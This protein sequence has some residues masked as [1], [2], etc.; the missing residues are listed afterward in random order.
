ML[1]LA[2][3]QTSDQE[4]RADI[5]IKAQQDL[6]FAGLH[7]TV[8]N[9]IANFTGNCPSEKAFK[10]IQQTIKNIHVLKAVNYNVN[11][12]PVK[13]DTLTPIKLQVD[14]LLAQYPQ[15]IAKVDTASIT[16]KGTITALNKAKLIKALS[17]THYS[18]VND[19]LT[20]R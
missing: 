6:N 20:V 4:I 9:G 1:A 7:Y 13:L 18:A 17:L 5:A 2:G 10:K 14:S 8:S 19:S 3:C 15:V 16:L 11:I 12:A